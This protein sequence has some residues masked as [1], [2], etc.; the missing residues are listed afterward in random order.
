[1]LEPLPLLLQ[2]CK[3]ILLPTMI[4]ASIR[5]FV[6]GRSR[7]GGVVVVPEYALQLMCFVVT[8]PHAHA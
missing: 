2:L 3:T 7:Q 4:G 8:L 6:P 5:G 1:M